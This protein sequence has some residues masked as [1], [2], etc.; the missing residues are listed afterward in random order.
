VGWGGRGGLSGTL[1]AHNDTLQGTEGRDDNNDKNK[2][3]KFRAVLSIILHFTV[4]QV[5]DIN[6]HNIPALSH[7]RNC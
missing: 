2:Q 3:K 5:Y 6:K 7:R 4:K 1:S